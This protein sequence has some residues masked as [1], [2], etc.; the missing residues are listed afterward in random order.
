VTRIALVL[1]P[2]LMLLVFAAAPAVAGK[3]G[4]GFVIAK[5]LDGTVAINPKAV[6]SLF[7]APGTGAAST[8]RVNL[9]AG[10]LQTL[11]GPAA[12][13]AWAAF[14]DGPGAKRFLF[15]DHLGGTL[16]IPVKSVH[17][18]YRTGAGA[19]AK[20]RI[21]YAGDDKTV[22]GDEAERVWKRLVE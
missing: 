15:L 2:A 6:A 14:H 22:T 9:E 8:L 17:T 18:L 5:H 4:E 21:V 11:E 12:D 16:G 10:G 1:G 3:E 13:A 20:L 19:D 7:R